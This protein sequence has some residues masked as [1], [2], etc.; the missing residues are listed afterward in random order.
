M[1]EA[2]LSLI[3]YTYN[4]GHFVDSLLAEV[5][6]WTV[7]PDEIIILDDGSSHAYVPPAFPIPIRLIRHATNQGITR[8]KH[9]AIS[10]ASS[11]FLLAMDCD[12]RLA[13]DWIAT[14][15][16]HARRSAVGMV[17]GPAI[18]LSGNDLISRFQRAFGDNHNLGLDGPTNFI[19]GNAFLL[20]R[21]VW[22]RSGGLEGFDP[23]VCEDH[24]L[25]RKIKDLDL[26]LW[27]DP[28]A[29]LQQI[30]RINRIAMLKRYW[31]WC[32]LAVKKAALAT[33]NFEGYVYATLVIPHS[34]RLKQCIELEEPLFVYLETLYLSFTIL[35]ILDHLIA[36]GRTTVDSKTAL[37][38]ELGRIFGP[39]P[40][41]HA[42]LRADLM[43]LGQYPAQRG[44]PT[45]A[46]P[47]QAALEPLEVI[48]KSGILSWLD[49]VGIPAMRQEEETLNYDFSFYE[50]ATRRELQA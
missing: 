6:N 40:V 46:N 50:H 48:G 49:K 33:D 13:A 27:I 29:T 10:A 24:Y 1:F 28:K 38:M 15:L 11:E 23:D 19:P 31:K 16:P 12:T 42:S 30:R 36:N 26:L 17:S 34:Q 43:Q 32:H 39:F 22:E 7:Q 18:Y 14:C 4:D 9:E 37:W 44:E 8:T 2:S 25:C 35:D 41:L 45:Q 3:T 21:E 5:H 47:W 20:R